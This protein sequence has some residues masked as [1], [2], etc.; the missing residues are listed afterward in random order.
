MPVP[1]FIASGVILL[2]RTAAAW[3]GYYAAQALAALGLYF[4]IA[5]PGTDWLMEAMQ[6]QF[7]LV[8]GTVYETLM[9]CNVDDFVGMC[10]SALAYKTAMNASVKV[11]GRRS[12][13]TPGAPS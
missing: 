1:A 2:V 8:S 11:R 7:N 6:D 5:E 9:Y 12:R 4:F 10:L 13:A 3:A